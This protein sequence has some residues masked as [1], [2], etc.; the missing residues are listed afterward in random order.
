M[1][2]DN[3]VFKNYKRSNIWQREYQKVEKRTEEIN[4]AMMIQNFLKLMIDIK[5]QFRKLREPQAG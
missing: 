5:Q 1:T 2:K 3:R 4:E